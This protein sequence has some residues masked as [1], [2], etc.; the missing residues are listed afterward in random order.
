M[1]TAG[2][3]AHICSRCLGQGP[4]E[5]QGPPPTG[6]GPTSC[7]L[8]ETRSLTEPAADRGATFQSG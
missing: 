7:H 3:E 8:D 4:A 2:E 1:P 5:L 6:A